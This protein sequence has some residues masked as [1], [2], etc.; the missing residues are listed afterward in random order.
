MCHTCFLGILLDIRVNPHITPVAQPYRRIPIHVE[1]KVEK[2][3]DVMLERKIV[4][5]VDEPCR[6]V[7]PM[8]PVIKSN[9]DVRIC[10]DMRQANKAIVRE[11]HPLPTLDTILPKLSG[12]KFFS[13]LDIKNAFHQIELAPESRFITTFITKRG[14][15]RYT[16]LIFGINN[17]PELFQKTLE[18][19]LAGCKNVV[20]YLD[21]ILV[22]GETKEQHDEFL[23]LVKEKLDQF[24]ILLNE[25]KLEIGKTSVM[26][27]GHVVS[28]QGIRPGEGKLDAIKKFRRPE[29]PEEVRSFLGLVTYLGRFIP[30]LATLSDPLRRLIIEGTTLKKLNWIN[31]HEDCFQ[32]IK[33]TITTKATLGYFDN[34]DE[35]IVITDAS[36]VGLGALLIQR[37]KRTAKE[38]LITCVS[39]SL[40]EV[41]R[42]YC[43][44]EKEALAIVWAVERL[45]YYLFGKPFTLV[46]DHKPL[47]YMFQPTAKPSARI[48]RWV[49]RIQPFEFNVVY[50]KGKENI[51]D[52]LSRLSA[53]DK[54]P[55]Q[56]DEDSEH[57]VNALTEASD[58]QA[59]QIHEIKTCS[60]NDD[61][62]KEIQDGLENSNS[63]ND[64]DKWRNM[65]H[66]LC[67]TNGILLR[68][69]RIYIPRTL[70]E[71]ILEAGHEGHPGREK[72]L[73]RLREKIW[74]PG[75]TR[76]VEEK[77]KSCLYC[78]LV[79]APDRPIPLKMRDMPTKPWKELAM[80]FTSTS[81]FGKELLVVVDYYS[82][83]VVIKIQ[84]S[85]GHEETIRNLEEIFAIFGFPQTITC[86]NG[87]PYNSKELKTYCNNSGITIL[88]TPPMLAQANGLVE[89]QNR[90]IKKVLQISKEKKS[91]DW[92]HDLLVDYLT[93]YRGTAQKTTNMS[94]FELLFGRKMRDK[95]PMLDFHHEQ[96]QEVRERDSLEKQKMKMRADNSKRATET[97]IVV[98]DKVF[99]KNPKNDKLTTNFSPEIYTVTSIK[100]GDCTVQSDT[101]S[102][103]RRRHVSFMKK[104]PAA[105]IPGNT[106]PPINIC[107]PTKPNNN[108][109]KHDS[110]ISDVPSNS[111]LLK[112]N[113]EASPTR[114]KRI[115]TAPKILKDYIR[116]TEQN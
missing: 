10:I 57:Y 39:K 85:T 83:Y 6:W 95:I 97:R 26:F 110:G 88:H 69:H 87:P 24:N 54:N 109:D 94:P 52:S 106:T 111:Q 12:S 2:E 59:V 50:R 77:T 63:R 107:S 29:S 44:T 13:K 100:G 78:V 80:D 27:M 16:R 60:E 38:R 70:R 104:V 45:H 5:M 71:R 91:K 74:W 31:S 75:L 58:I 62:F 51:A 48:E 66:E 102:V 33:E 99:L 22:F 25:E 73:N 92:K 8:V 19:V 103:V 82:R 3:L 105:L 1:E 86:D 116:R 28:A 17:A 81:T 64:S 41:E 55:E 76:G 79:S 112:R 15:M 14:L 90:S 11:K 4:E 9:G 56:F 32:K 68:G 20:I 98:G 23:R 72:M 96:N 113:N 114:P 49:L 21:D 46:T 42:R 30:D 61:F 34:K 40:T 7:S 89:R 18:R 47:T 65:Y 36:P 115:R 43:T 84:N 53:V 93:M 37:D 101:T 67:I 35:T 108:E